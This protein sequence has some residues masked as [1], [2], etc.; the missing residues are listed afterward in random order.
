V[1]SY[2]PVRVP[3]GATGLPSPGVLRQAFTL[4]RANK[5]ADRMEMKDT[6][7]AALYGATH[8]VIEQK[9]AEAIIAKRQG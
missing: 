2:H 5:E 8:K 9:S 3:V 4:K 6:G 7:R 1:F